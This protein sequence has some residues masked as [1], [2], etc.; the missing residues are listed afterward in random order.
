[1]SNFGQAALTVVG[2]VVGFLLGGPALGI[3]LG[4]TLGQILFPT[5]LGTVK[6]PRLQDLSV[7]S[8]AIG[9]P[10]PIVYGTFA[11]AGNII[12]S[13]GLIERV[14]KKRAGGKGGPTQ[15]VKTYHYSV[16]VAI[17]LCEGE[18]RAIRKIWADAKLIY[19]L[20]PQGEAES[21]E[22]YNARLAISDQTAQVMVVYRGTETQVADPTI[23]SYLGVGEALAYRGLAYVVFTGFEL[24]LF[25]NR[26][27]NF[28]FEIASGD[29]ATEECTTYSNEVLFPWAEGNDPRNVLNQHEITIEHIGSVDDGD[30]YIG[31]VGALGDDDYQAFLTADSNTDG[32][33]FQYFGGFTDSSTSTNTSMAPGNSESAGE[34]LWLYLHYN[35]KLANIFGLR[36]DALNFCDNVEMYSQTPGTT[37]WMGLVNSAFGFHVSTST[38]Q[39][40][41]E[42]DEGPGG[43]ADSTW[44]SSVVCHPYSIGVKSSRVL[45]VERIPRPPIDTADDPR[46]VQLPGSEN[47]FQEIATGDIVRGIVWTYTTGTFKVLQQYDEVDEVVVKYPLNPALP[48]THEDYNDQAFWEAAYAAAVAAGDMEAGLDYGVDYPVVQAWGYV[49]ECMLQTITTECM[50]V[51]NIIEDICNRVGFDDSDIDVSDIDSCTIGYCITRPMSARDAIEPLRT[52]GLFDAVE[53]GNQL[54]FIERGHAVVA[55]LEENDLAAHAAGEERPTV[56]EVVRTQEVDLPRRVRLHYLSQERNYEVAEQSASRITVNSK[57]E[58]DVELPVVMEDEEAA[59]LAQ[60][61]LYDAWVSRN[62]YTLAVTNN[63]IGLEPTDCIDAP[64]EG[65]LRRMRIVTE[66]YSI[67]GVKR[68]ECVHDDAEIYDLALVG[69]EVPVPSGGGPVAGVVCN[70]EIVLIDIPGLR[71]QDRDAGYYAAVQGLCDTWTGAEIYRSGDGGVDYEWVGETMLEATIG[72]V[73]EPLAGYGSPPEPWLDSPLGYDTTS[74]LIVQLR[75][76]DSLESVTDAQIENGANTSVVGIDGRWEIIQFKTATLVSGDLWELT[77]LIRGKL[78]TDEFIGTGVEG[79]T[80]VLMA[81]QA[82]LR[83]AELPAAIGVE[84]LFKVPTYGQSL[85]SAAVVAF[86]TQGLSYIPTTV[87]GLDDVDTTGAN[88]GDVL[89]YDSTTETWGPE[90][91][92]TDTGTTGK[93]AIYIHAAAMSPSASGGCAPI[94]TVTTASGQPDLQTLNFDAST[95]EYAQFSIRMPKSWNEGTVTFVPVWSHP[96]TVTDFGVVWD[97]QGVAISND[98]TILSNFGTAQTSTDTG[99]TTS[100]IYIGPESSPITIAGTPQAEDM[101]FFRVSRVTGNGSNTLAVDARLHGITLYI[102]TDAEND[103]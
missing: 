84:K 4:S 7:Q 30:N 90:P 26:I 70:S 31:P 69:G 49:G 1:M 15:T 87:G 32:R 63:H 68:L 97:L 50:P 29:I 45:K 39:L 48:S 10:I 2:G 89:T 13:S 73:I 79:D 8:S 54:K 103:A 64:V 71:E 66:Q 86:T 40:I 78:E 56:M 28:R 23:E 18:I 101:V 96:A 5:N 94:A 47:Y 82:M 67:G 44:D 75:S 60:V 88:D 43:T 17:G 74:T 14:K 53:S 76:G 38:V 98:D 91:L 100:D 46:Y 34:H 41:L 72:D 35:T 59:A 9:A 61:L 42:D 25:G 80:F 52:F 12:W 57:F 37:V 77:D 62:A 81:D 16:D 83:I 99:G 21:D 95:Q 58:L 65:E 92:P 22:D 55:T 102:T 33:N 19:D 93:H 3:Y 85:D 27:P 11:I 20:S 6:G 36:T 51:A 24:E